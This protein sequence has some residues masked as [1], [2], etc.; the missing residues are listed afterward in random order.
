MI[1][2]VGRALLALATIGTIGVGVNAAQAAPVPVSN[3]LVAQQRVADS[4]LVDVDFDERRNVDRVSFRFRGGVPDDVSARLV[5]TVRDRDGDRVRLPG[6]FAVVLQFEDTDARGFGR[7]L[8]D[9]DL[10]NVLA[11]RLVDDGR[12]DDV[13]RVAVALRERA[14]IELFERGNRIVLDVDSRDRDRF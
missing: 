9:A 8:R 5:R 13:V 7:G 1:R 3:P 14:D 4:R 2:L 10:R 12:R 11:V 6:R